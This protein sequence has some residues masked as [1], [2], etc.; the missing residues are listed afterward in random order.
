[1]PEKMEEVGVS[2]QSRQDLRMKDFQLRPQSK[3]ISQTDHC[4]SQKPTKG[5]IDNGLIWITVLCNSLNTSKQR[6]EDE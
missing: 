4:Q 6:A 2:K 3:K 5:D 1:M